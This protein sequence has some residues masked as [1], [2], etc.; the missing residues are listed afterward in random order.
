M[1]RGTNQHGELGIGNVT[2]DYEFLEIEIENIQQI[3]CG[4]AHT[5]I[6]MEDG[7]VMGCG[8]NVYGQ[9]GLDSSVLNIN[10]FKKIRVENVKKIICDGNS[11]FFLSKN[12]KLLN[13]GCSRLDSLR[14][15]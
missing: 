14:I 10:Q 9:L 2:T 5:V 3:A 12:G 4:R 1:V 8:S 15:I 13:C 6:L 7:S 11:T